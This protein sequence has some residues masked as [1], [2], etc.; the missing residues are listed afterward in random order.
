MLCAAIG[1][2]AGCAGPRPATSVSF[3]T[4]H[5]C[6]NTNTMRANLDAALHSV[7]LPA[8]YALIDADTLSVSDP[9]RGYGTPTVL[10]GNDDLFEK[11]QPTVRAQAPT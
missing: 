9:R 2:M 11:P 8:D 1:V 6:V 7:G 4:R 3:L 5:D 10:V